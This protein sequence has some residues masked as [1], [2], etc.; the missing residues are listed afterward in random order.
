M[1]VA[2]TGSNSVR[3]EKASYLM[4][5]FA[6]L[7]AQRLM[8]RYMFDVFENKPQECTSIRTITRRRGS[9]CIRRLSFAVQHDFPV[10]RVFN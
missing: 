4:S 2:S 8:L 6:Q 5:L 9:S 10:K 1:W 3:V 7:D